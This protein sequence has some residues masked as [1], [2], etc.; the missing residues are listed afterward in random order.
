[1]LH[2]KT[3]I[4]AVQKA[5]RFVCVR[6]FKPNEKLVYEAKVSLTLHLSLL[7]HVLRFKANL[8]S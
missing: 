5:N 6:E 7:W 1:M 8:A 3:F 4:S 2:L